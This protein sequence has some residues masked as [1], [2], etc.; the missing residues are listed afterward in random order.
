MI[1]SWRMTAIGLSMFC[2]QGV[3]FS[4][5]SL[6]PWVQICCDLWISKWYYKPRH[7]VHIQS[8]E[9]NERNFLFIFAAFVKFLWGSNECYSVRS[10][11]SCLYE[12][13]KNNV[14]HSW[15]ILYPVLLASSDTCP[16]EIVSDQLHIGLLF[17]VSTA[18]G[19]PIFLSG[20]PGIPEFENWKNLE[21]KHKKN[22]SHSFTQYHPIRLAVSVATVLMYTLGKLLYSSDQFVTVQCRCLFRQCLQCIY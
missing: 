7:V 14:L 20:Y 11:A 21:K 5:K 9:F 17:S 12:S 6:C 2:N 19:Y 15:W 3:Q 10:S 1:Q 22:I 13:L 18:T 16:T 4:R 8:W